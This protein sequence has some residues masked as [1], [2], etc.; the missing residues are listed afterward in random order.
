VIDHFKYTSDGKK[1]RKNH[2]LLTKPSNVKLKG[3]VF[4]KDGN[5]LVEE[6]A[7]EA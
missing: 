3:G 1:L 5:A 6:S 4:G 7:S 2:G